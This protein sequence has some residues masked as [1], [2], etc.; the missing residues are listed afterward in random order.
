MS[1][2]AHPQWQPIRNSHRQ[3]PRSHSSL[4]A[5]NQPPSP[6]SPPP[7]P[8]LQPLPPTPP[9]TPSPLPPSPSLQAHMSAV[10]G[11]ALSP[12]GWLLLSAGRDKVVVVWDLRR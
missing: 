3:P 12:D 11:L 8:S 5:P 7:P 9:S 10:T 4:P 6:A 1:Q 2:D